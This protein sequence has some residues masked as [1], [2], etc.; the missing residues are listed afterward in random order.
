[1]ERSL[2]E[3]VDALLAKVRRPSRY[4][5]IEW[6]ARRPEG[7]GDLLLAV[8]KAYEE[9]VLDPWL[10][11]VYQACVRAGL[12]VERA[13]LPDPDIESLLKAEG[14]P[15]FRGATRTVRIRIVWVVEMNSIIPR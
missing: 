13:F 3:R 5:G 4:I 11:G 1:M 9:G 10:N 15:W 8:P 14:V 12:R 2:N 6:N 7:R